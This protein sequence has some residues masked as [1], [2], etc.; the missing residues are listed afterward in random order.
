MLCISNQDIG[1]STGGRVRDSVLEGFGSSLMTEPPLGNANAICLLEGRTFVE[2]F[3]NS[4]YASSIP[5]GTGGAP[6]VGSVHDENAGDAA[7]VWARRVTIQRS[8]WRPGASLL[9]R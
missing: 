2:V 3:M 7:A 8:R 5:Y 1:K 4:P 9:C 6:E